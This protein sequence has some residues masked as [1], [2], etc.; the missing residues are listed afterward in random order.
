MIGGT[1][2]MV[3]SAQ[4]STKLE[5]LKVVWGFSEGYTFHMSNMVD[6]HKGMLTSTDEG[7]SREEQIKR[8]EQQ[9]E[10]HPALGGVLLGILAYTQSFEANMTPI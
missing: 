1:S 9:H 10:Q 7:G 5:S 2:A 4:G 8:F 6:R 3:D